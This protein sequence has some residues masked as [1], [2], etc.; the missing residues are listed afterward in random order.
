[1]LF[2]YGDVTCG[3]I[4]SKQRSPSHS[5]HK[6]PHPKS[7]DADGRTALLAYPEGDAV[8]LGEL[9][10]GEVGVGP[11]DVVLADGHGVDLDL[12]GDALGVAG[13]EV[14]SEGSRRP[15]RRE[16]REGGEEEERGR[17]RPHGG[18]GSGAPRGHRRRS[19]RSRAR[20]GTRVWL[21]GRGR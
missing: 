14:E 10:V 21:V 17:A 7:P 19:G 16:E 2:P 6:H 5:Q 11:D 3:T 12:V 20:R 8:R 13:L 18:G 9:G 1:M 15:R 4:N